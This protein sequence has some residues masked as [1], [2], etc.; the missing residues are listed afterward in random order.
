M[1][2]ASV[3]RELEAYAPVDAVVGNMDGPALRDELPERMHGLIDQGDLNKDGALDREEL[4][5]LAARLERQGPPRD[6]QPP[7]RKRSLTSST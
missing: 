3:L 7:P 2:A 6:S 5:Q 1:T 4:R